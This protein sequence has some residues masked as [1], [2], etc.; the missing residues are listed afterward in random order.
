MDAKKLTIYYDG[1][2][3]LCSREVETYRSKDQ[4]DRLKLVDISRSDFSAQKEGLDPQEVHRFF[5]VRKKNGEVVKGLEAFNAIWKEL[6][7]FKPLQLMADLPL[8]RDLMKLGYQAF[9][10]VRPYLPKRKTCEDDS[11]EI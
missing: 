8:T 2:C 1:A 9:A 5:H 6:N 11:C 7:I 10:K 4:E 3:H